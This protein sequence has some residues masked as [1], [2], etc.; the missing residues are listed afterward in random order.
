VQGAE[1]TGSFGLSASV[2]GGTWDYIEQVAW[3][4]YRT[5]FTRN[6]DYLVPSRL[7]SSAIRPGV[8]LEMGIRGGTM[9]GTQLRGISSYI[10]DYIMATGIEADFEG[11]APVGVDVIAP[12]RTLAEKL[13]LL[14]DA[15]RL[16]AQGNGKSLGK[17]D[18]TSTTSISF[19]NRRT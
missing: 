8:R 16:A 6:A 17:R 11:L 18:V 7:D 9:P 2:S 3:L 10:A 15:G 13:A 12:V 14:H 1:R 5:G 19:S 4:P